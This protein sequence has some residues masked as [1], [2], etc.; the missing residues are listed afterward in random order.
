MLDV[1][2][3]NQLFKRGYRIGTVEEVY[4]Y[5]IGLHPEKSVKSFFFNRNT[6]RFVHV[7]RFVDSYAN[8]VQVRDCSTQEVSDCSVNHLF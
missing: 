3:L 2:Y 7:E 4:G 8:T 1:D 6:R 5:N